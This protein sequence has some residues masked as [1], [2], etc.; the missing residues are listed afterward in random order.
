MKV[1]KNDINA[2]FDVLIESSCSTM[3]NA[4]FFEQFHQMII[5]ISY[6]ATDI[7]IDYREREIEMNVAAA[8]SKGDF[9]IRW[10]SSVPAA[11]CLK[12]S[13]E[14]LADFLKEA[15]KKKREIAFA[16]S[17]LLKTHFFSGKSLVE[18]LR[19]LAKV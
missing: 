2:D 5:A 3:E 9:L 1:L 12:L 18:K 4:K 15:L 13:Y 16:H 17:S 19:P 11:E 8:Y 6:D 7:Y 14:N 10:D